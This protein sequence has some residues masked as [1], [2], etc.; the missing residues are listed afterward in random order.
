[1]ILIPPF[2]AYVKS[3]NFF[4]QIN[5]IYLFKYLEENWGLC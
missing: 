2:V 3:K 1:M 4:I 5:I